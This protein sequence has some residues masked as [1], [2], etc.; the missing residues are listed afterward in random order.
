MTERDDLQG[1]VHRFGSDVAF[2]AGSRASLLDV[3]AGQDAVRYRDLEA[4]SEVCQ[5]ASDSVSEDVEMRRLAAYQA[6][7]RHD[8]VEPPGRRDR[9]HRPG[10]LERARHVEFLDLRPR[11]QGTRGGSLRQTA[12]DLFV[13]AG[14]NDCH[15]G[16]DK[17]VSHSRGRLPTLRHMA[18]S[19]PRMTPLWA[20]R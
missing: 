9:R 13:P 16:T 5:R 17:P 14:P 6:A 4:G 20:A 15:P 12:G 11:R 1:R 3:L 2:P 7:K 19:S 18:Q 8:C 10:Q